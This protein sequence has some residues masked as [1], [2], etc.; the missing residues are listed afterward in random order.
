MDAQIILRQITSSASH[1]I[2][3]H[4]IRFLVRRSA[5]ALDPGP[6]AAAVRFRPDRLNLDPVAG[7]ASVTS[8]ELWIVIHRVDHNIDVAIV[9]EVAK[10]ATPRRRGRIDPRPRLLR[11]IL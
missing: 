5:H 4:M 6:D 9:I 2:D 7:E 8:Q 11:Y 3:L 1:L 10:R